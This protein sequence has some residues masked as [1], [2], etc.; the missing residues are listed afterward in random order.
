M[1]CQV[2]IESSTV[3]LLN[4]ITNGLKTFGPINGSPY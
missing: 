3:E 2:S 4:T 1:H